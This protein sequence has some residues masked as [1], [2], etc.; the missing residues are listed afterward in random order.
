MQSSKNFNQQLSNGLAMHKKGLLIEAKTIYEQILNS[1]PDHF[2]ALQLLGAISIQTKDYEKC[3]NLLNNALQ[4]KNNYAPT[5]YNLGLALHE[6]EKFNEAIASYH[7][8]LEI[9]PYYSQAHN[10]LACALKALHQY[11]SAITYFNKAIT[12]NPSYAEAHNNIGL[13]KQELKEYSAAI[14]NYEKAISL[15]P[16]YYEAFYN[17]GIALIGLNQFTDAISTFNQTLKLE[18][19]F[20]KAFNG[21]GHANQ[22]LLRLTEAMSNYE[23]AILKDPKFA[24]ALWNKSLLKILL[25][26]YP[27]GWSL[28]EHRWKVRKFKK[29][30]RDFNQPLWLGE[31]TIQNKIILI[32]AE[33]G[34]GDSIQFCRYIPM[35]E[36]LGPRQIILEIPKPLTSIISTVNSKTILLEKGNPI[37]QFDLH[38]PMMSL[39]H[40]FRTTLDNIPAQIPYLNADKNKVLDWSKMLGDPKNPR[41]GIVWSGSS[42]HPNDHNRSL[43]FKQLAPL[44]ILPFE[45]H[46][47]Q[48]EIKAVD[49]VSLKNFKQI[50]QHQDNLI[51]F[52]DTAALIEN[53][54]LVITVD[55]SIAH[56]AGALG[57][58]VFILLPFVPDYR[59][60]LD[61]NDSPWYPTATLFRQPKL[62]DWESVINQIKLALESNLPPHDEVLGK[63][64]A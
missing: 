47:L 32:H 58:R 46:S 7:Q 1:Q 53:L 15:K 16:D 33:Q 22:E 55:T 48:K 17:K 54:E 37:P 10:G 23:K 25:G 24:D 42:N 45:F 50:H 9:N 18:P 26:E 57:K 29:E 3:I 35:I 36:S 6:L 64:N 21:L 38:C 30:S 12:L 11:D 52:S 40:A 61:R 49:L 59:W 2:D 4:I 8:A 20:A 28:Y 43:L 41:V 63:K 34:L 51:D 56:L 14:A 31:N 60:M 19:D 13:V 5:Y 62:N 27:E 39:P 44:L